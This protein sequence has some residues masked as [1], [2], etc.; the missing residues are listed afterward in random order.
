MDENEVKKR[1]REIL[2]AYKTNPSILAKQYG[3]NQKTLNNQINGDTAISLSTILLIIEFLPDISV[4]WLLCGSGEMCK[5]TNS[6]TGAN[7]VSGKNATVIGQQLATLPENFVRDLLAEK[8]KQ[9]QTLLT[10]LGK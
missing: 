2:G 1:L 7:N 9:I 5:T 8:D 6:I 4:D 10:L 3:V